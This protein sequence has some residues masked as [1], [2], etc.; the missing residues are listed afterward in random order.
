MNQQ[1][2]N[3]NTI[4]SRAQIDKQYNRIYNTTGAH[5]AE[6]RGGTFRAH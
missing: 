4:K 5:G 1:Q 6:P 2:Q 3:K